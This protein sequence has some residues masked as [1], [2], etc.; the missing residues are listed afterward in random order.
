MRGE[1]EREAYGRDRDRDRD[2]DREGGG[3]SRGP[4]VYRK[5]VCRFCEEKV[6]EIDYKDTA[7]LSKYVTE[8][9]KIIPSRISG[10][11]AKHQ[12]SLARSIKRARHVALL[13]N[14]R[15]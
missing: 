13:S 7:R 15:M 6:S 11:C 12:R 1:G 2:R 3:R 8:R 5:K 4:R 9:G 10:V 14:I